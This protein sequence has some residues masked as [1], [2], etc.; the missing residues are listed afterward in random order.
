MTSNRLARLLLAT[1][2]AATLGLG[3]SASPASAAVVDNDPVRVLTGNVDIG[4]GA[5]VAGT[6]GFA[7]VAWDVSPA[8]VVTPTLTGELY[9][10]NPGTCARVRLES[11]DAAHVVIN[12]RPGITRCAVL[13]GA[14]QWPVTLSNTGTTATRHVHVIAQVLSA[15]GVWTDVNFT[16]ADLF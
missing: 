9:I 3:I 4:A 16:T 8:G 11:R 12:S 14:I 15:A 6:P 7:D 13:G 10:A 2:S 5:I 1:L